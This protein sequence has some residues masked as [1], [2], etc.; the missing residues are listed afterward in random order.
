MV[1]RRLRVARHPVE[2]LLIGVHVGARREL[3]AVEL[4]ER[5]PAEALPCAR[6][7]QG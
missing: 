4:V 6:T 1:V 5:R 3:A 7:T 2:D